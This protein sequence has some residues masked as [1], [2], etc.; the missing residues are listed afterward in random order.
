MGSSSTNTA[1]CDAHSIAEAAG[2]SELISTRHGQAV[3]TGVCCAS[4]TNTA[5]PG[6]G[7]SGSFNATVAAAVLGN[8]FSTGSAYHPPG[9]ILVGL[10]HFLLA[11]ERGNAA[12]TILRVLEPLPGVDH[13]TYPVRWML[14][15]TELYHRCGTPGLMW[16]RFF[17]VGLGLS[18]TCPVLGK[19]DLRT[20]TRS[21]TRCISRPLSKQH[22]SGSLASSPKVAQA[23]KLIRGTTYSNMASARDPCLHKWN[24]TCTRSV[25][26]A[27]CT[28]IQEACLRMGHKCWGI[29]DDKCDTVNVMLVDGYIGVTESPMA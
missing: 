29:F 28:N 4:A 12:P 16:Q 19:E 3:G 7:T 14:S 6:G 27:C 15:C 13:H 2:N 20:T 18:S 8:L 22:E 25:A 9:M 24:A 26:S 23:T 10:V 21:L 17:A 1:Q 11:R 5:S